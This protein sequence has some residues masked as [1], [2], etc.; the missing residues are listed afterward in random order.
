MV[1]DAASMEASLSSVLEHVAHSLPA[2]EV[3]AL[4]GAIGKLRAMVHGGMVL[5]GLR[6]VRIGPRELHDQIR[7][8]P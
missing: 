5:E 7:N 4:N 3:H 1:D 8:R 2:A 6:L